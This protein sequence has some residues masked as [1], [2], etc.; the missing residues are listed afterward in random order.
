VLRTSGIEPRTLQTGARCMP[1]ELES[2]QKGLTTHEGLV[3][4]VLEGDTEAGVGEGTHFKLQESRWVCRKTT[5][6]KEV[7][8]G[9]ACT[10][11]E[12]TLSPRDMTSLL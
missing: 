10:W 8:S 12:R 9:P 7:S 4:R 2:V 1:I 11:V 5:S 6:M 3:D